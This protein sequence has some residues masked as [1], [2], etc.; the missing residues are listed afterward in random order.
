MTEKLVL[1]EG[2]TLNKAKGDSLELENT[3]ETI[4][5]VKCTYC[6]IYFEGLLITN[7]GRHEGVINIMPSNTFIWRNVLPKDRNKSI[8]MLFNNLA[9][10]LDKHNERHSND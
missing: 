7:Y 4:H 8:K 1:P 10:K 3:V 5:F 6:D 2:I 9:L